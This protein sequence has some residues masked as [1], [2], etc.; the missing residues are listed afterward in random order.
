RTGAG[1][2]YVESFNAGK[3]LHQNPPLTVQQAISTDQ[4]APP[5]FTIASG[6]PAAIVPDLSKP[7]L[8]DGNATEFDPALKPARSMQWS[9]GIQ[10]QL[11]DN[12]LLDVSYVGSRTL[13]L[14][15]SVNANQAVAGPGAFN[16]RRPLYGPDPLLQDVDL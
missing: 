4:N 14:I 2:F 9:F 6:L 12:L 7:A 13:F 16:P 5:P 10:R 11:R 15:N 3:Q 8:Y 1:F